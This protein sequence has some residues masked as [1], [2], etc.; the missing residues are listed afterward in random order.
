M[1]YTRTGLASLVPA[2]DLPPLSPHLA[3]DARSRPVPDLLVECCRPRPAYRWN[4]AG[5]SPPPRW[6]AAGLAL[7]PRRNAPGP[8]T[9]TVGKL[10]VGTSCDLQGSNSSSLSTAQACIPPCGKHFIQSSELL[11]EVVGAA[12]GDW[13]EWE[14]TGGSLIRRGPIRALE[15]SKYTRYCSQTS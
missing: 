4:A 9:V 1:E 5:F 12:T 8:V 10:Q 3:L 7:S 15:K 6:T 13:E 2:A 14:S 11:G